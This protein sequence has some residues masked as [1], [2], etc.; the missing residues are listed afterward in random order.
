V[1]GAGGVVRTGTG[2]ASSIAALMVHHP[3]PESETR[4]EKSE[5]AASLARA[6]AVK[7]SN[8]EAPVVRSLAEL[9][10]IN[11]AAR[12]GISHG[13][14]GWWPNRSTSG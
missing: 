3:S 8:H 2:T 13:F 10:W 7:S 11:P 1:G 4:P 14:G 12:C 6:A 5:S 9:T